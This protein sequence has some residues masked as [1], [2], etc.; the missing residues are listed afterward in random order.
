MNSRHYPIIVSIDGR[1]SL[2]FLF[3]REPLN[4]R[5]SNSNTVT[6][7][8]PEVQWGRLQWRLLMP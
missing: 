7:L 4:I 5:N 2:P 6:G 3:V 1:Q 8:N